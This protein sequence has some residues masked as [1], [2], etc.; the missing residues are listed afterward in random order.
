MKK[1]FTLIELLAVIV[2]LVIIALIASPIVLN[3]IKDARENA[4]KETF[5]NIE[6]SAKLYIAKGLLDPSIQS[7]F[8]GATN[9]FDELEYDGDE[10]DFRIVYVNSNNQVAL[11]L[12]INDVC[13]SKDYGE[14]SIATAEPVNGEC[15]IGLDYFSFFNITSGS[16]TAV[17]I[18]TGYTATLTGTNNNESDIVNQAFQNGNSLDAMCVAKLTIHV[19]K[20]GI[21][22]FEHN[23]EIRNVC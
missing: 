12:L 23:F 16:I 21:N 11:A 3:I 14:N 4:S 18:P 19:F 8:D 2:I 17:N 22:V 1:G 6:E 10:P 7:S 15:S 20:N 13:Y 5:N 9:I